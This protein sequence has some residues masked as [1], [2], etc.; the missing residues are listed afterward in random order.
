ME[1]KFRLNPI[2][3]VL[4]T[5]RLSWTAPNTQSVTCGHMLTSF[6]TDWNELICIIN[7]GNV[8]LSSSGEARSIA[9]L[10]QSFDTLLE[11]PFWDIIEEPFIT[12][13]ESAELEVFFYFPATMPEKQR[14]RYQKKFFQNRYD[15]KI[16]MA[17]FYLL[18][19]FM[20]KPTKVISSFNLEWLQPSY[21][22]L[23]HIVHDVEATYDM[24]I[25][26]KSIIR[27]ASTNLMV[28]KITP[29]TINELR[30][31]QDVRYRAWREYYVQLMCVR[32]ESLRISK[33]FLTYLADGLIYDIDEFVF[34]NPLIIAKMRHKGTIQEL[35]DVLKRINEQMIQQDDA[36]D[37]Q[38]LDELRG[39]LQEQVQFAE[40]NVLLSNVAIVNLSALST[41]AFKWQSKYDINNMKSLLFQWTYA[42]L[43]L[44]THVG[45]LHT[46]A[47]IGN[48]FV[49]STLP[50]TIQIDDLFYNFKDFRGVLLDFSQVIINPYF[51][52]IQSMTP[53]SM[54]VL[55]QEQSQYLERFLLSMRSKYANT[56]AAINLIHRDFNRAFHILSIL[57]P[58][59]MLLSFQ[60]DLRKQ[61]NVPSEVQDLVEK[62]LVTCNNYLDTALQDPEKIDITEYPLKHILIEYFREISSPK[63]TAGIVYIF[64][65]P[66]KNLSTIRMKDPDLALLQANI[67]ITIT[68]K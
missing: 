21:E 64:H 6:S 36:S 29:L 10:R 25:L 23:E 14:A 57:D 51:P 49:G 61:T 55:V 66:L 46:D 22:I 26:R 1:D 4:A 13:V 47:H 17:H 9:I 60:E 65:Q 3:N 18:L 8:T 41:R 50:F 38:K 30:N 58:I 35:H 48:L 32:I 63:R 56:A 45:V 67:A 24:S 52:P 44:H 28:S 34:S 7:F 68:K 11:Q 42:L 53:A 62:L 33:S 39:H 54:D 27:I 40:Q 16:A 37:S 31:I 43:V 12:F 19:E 59:F 15:F 5:V 20:S 2:N